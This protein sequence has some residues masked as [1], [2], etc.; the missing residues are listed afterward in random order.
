MTQRVNK[1][2]KSVKGWLDWKPCQSQT[3]RATFKDNWSFRWNR[4][5]CEISPFIYYNSSHTNFSIGEQRQMLIQLVHLLQ[6]N[7]PAIQCT[8]CNIQNHLSPNISTSDAF[9]MILGHIIHL[10]QNSHHFGS[11]WSLKRS[12]NVGEKVALEKMRFIF[13]LW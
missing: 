12:L 3:P 10:Q 8:K 7:L 9:K 2:S 5:R 4:D 6:R 13:T 11:H 1:H